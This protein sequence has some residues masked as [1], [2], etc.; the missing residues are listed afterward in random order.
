MSQP[1]TNR[2]KET[3]LGPL[4]VD[5][6]VVRLGEVTTELRE[7]NS[8]LRFSRDDVL[9]IS[10]VTGFFPSDRTLGKDFSKYKIV[11][12][13]QFAY[14]P[15]RLNVGSIA[16]RLENRPGLVSP[17]YVVFKCNE[18]DL[19][20]EY[21]N[22]FR[23]TNVWWSQIQ[24]SGQGSV[25]IRYYYH[26]IADF[27]IPLPPLVEQRGIA[28]VLN[29]VQREIAAQEQLITAAREVKRSLMARLFTYGPGAEPAR[30]KETE[31]GEVP[32]HWEVVRLGELI[33]E[34]VKNGAF[35]KRDQFGGNVPFLNVADTYK[36][37]SVSIYELERVNCTSLRPLIGGRKNSFRPLIGGRKNSPPA[38]G[39]WS[40]VPG[41]SQGGRKSPN[42]PRWGNGIEL[43]IM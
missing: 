25:R 7:R 32:E 6:E 23:Y 1:I 28:R 36:D 15:M 34:Q 3:E 38:P 41:P 31:I 33:K 37:L 5:W 19:S 26:H 39:P 9:S 14:N 24:Q 27:L 18:S 20:P 16:I 35:V 13:R 10:N 2:F 42:S 30:T 4:P 17:D 40:L 11:Q 22:Q 8:E 29:A 12:H 43:R 21:C